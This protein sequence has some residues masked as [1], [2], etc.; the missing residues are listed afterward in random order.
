M[1]RVLEFTVMGRPQAK[2]RPRSARKGLKIRTYTPQKTIKQEGIF[3]LTF[4]T[5]LSRQPWA[6]YIEKLRERPVG[7]EIHAFFSPPKRWTKSKR[8]LHM[9]FHCFSFCDTDNISKL[10]MDGL[11]GSA[12]HDD[13]QVTKLLC[14]KWYGEPERVE[15]RVEWM[16]VPR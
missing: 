3:L 13:R 5:E 6:R 9:G 15:T 1:E 7:I 2:G 11:N 10:I 16:E 14:C 4:I 8:K 12:Y